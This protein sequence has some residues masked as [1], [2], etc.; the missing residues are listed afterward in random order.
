VVLE[1]VDGAVHAWPGSAAAP[2]PD[3]SEAGCRFDATA[4]VVAFLRTALG[5]A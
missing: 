1:A 3:N 2:R 4:E 5:P